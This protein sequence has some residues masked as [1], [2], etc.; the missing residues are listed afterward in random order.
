MRALGASAADAPVTD[1]LVET[2]L[3]A[4]G[5]LPPTAPACLARIRAANAATDETA[6]AGRFTEAEHLLAAVRGK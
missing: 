1:A 3:V 2:V 6:L 4:R 5:L